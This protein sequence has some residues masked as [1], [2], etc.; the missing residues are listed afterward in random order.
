MWTTFKVLLN[1]LQ[2]CF[3]CMFWFFGR[4]ACGILATRPGIQPA[5]PA[6]EGEVLTSGPPGKS[7]G[8]NFQLNIDETYLSSPALGLLNSI[9]EFK[10]KETFRLFFLQL[11]PYKCHRELLSHFIILFCC[12]AFV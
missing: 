12:T 7:L 1:S 11:T 4:Q 8:C 2:Y 10:G 9:C 6:V 5:T 3:C